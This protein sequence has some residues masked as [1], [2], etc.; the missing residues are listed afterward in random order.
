MKKNLLVAVA[1]VAISTGAMAQSAFEGFYGQLGVGYENNTFGSSTLNVGANSG[2]T[3]TG[4][5]NVGAP[6]Q[7]ASGFSGAIGL[8]YNYA[9]APRLLLGV[10]IDYNPMTL[11]SGQAAVCNGCGA[12]ST[13]KVSNRFNI[14]VTPGYEIDKD[15]LAYM[16]FGYTQEQVNM[17]L[18]AG[19]NTFTNSF[20]QT[21]NAGGYTIGLG[22]KQLVDKN[23]Y[24]FGEGNYMSYSSVGLSQNG[25]NAD[26]TGAQRVTINTTPSA[27]QFL[28]GVGYKF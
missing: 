18:P 6:T 25:N 12:Q 27:Y 22:Y 24:V 8:G 21:A 3:G 7:T 20:N 14:F 26:G 11:T 13:T 28:V 5:A 9:V 15:K 16:K 23:V 2:H 19:P 10:G 4:G 1:A 17:N